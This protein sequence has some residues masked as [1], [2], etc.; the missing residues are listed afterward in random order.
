[1]IIGP[2]WDLALVFIYLLVGPSTRTSHLKP[3]KD[4][5]QSKYVKKKAPKK[6]W[7][8]EFI[9]AKEFDDPAVSAACGLGS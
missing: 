3:K 7:A 5:M 9:W 1:V 6:Y 4:L 8:K 2:V